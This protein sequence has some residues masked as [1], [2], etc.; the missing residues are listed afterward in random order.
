MQKKLIALAVAGLVSGGAFAQSNVS[1]YGVVDV[2]I[3]HG[4]SGYGSQTRI[5]SGQSAGNRLGFRGEEALGNGLTAYFNLEQGFLLDD[6]QTSSNGS[7]TQGSGATTNGFASPTSARTNSGANVAQTNA[8]QYTFN[9]LAIAGLK[10]SWGSVQIGRQ[11]SPTFAVRAAVD[12]S[13]LGTAASMATTNPGTVDR[14]DNAILYMSPNMGGFTVGLGYTSGSENNSN[15]TV[16]GIGC[17]NAGTAAA[18]D[19]CN[20]DS[21][22]GWGALASYA[23]GPVYVGL[24]HHR[25]NGNGWTAAAGLLGQ[26]DNQTVRQWQLGGTYAFSAAKLHLLWGSNKAS[27]GGL[28]HPTNGD[29]GAD[30]V[31]WAMGVTM[32]MG[33]HKFIVNY[34]QQNGKL[35]S[36]LDFKFFGVHYEYALS[37]R[38]NFYAAYAKVS[39]DDRAGNAGAGTPAGSALGTGLIVNNA[40]GNAGNYDPNALQFGMR[41]SF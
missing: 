2:G 35:T 33:A 36:D 28:T 13:G 10:G 3:E 26:T 15:T 19:M 5:Q 30:A 24:A 20:K 9:R 27:G 7:L 29:R 31:G 22:K 1:I 25:V 4:N 6:G 34:G 12:S 8:G 18:T 14:L 39:N 37:K 11:Y 17:T 41:H 40:A 32:P 21:G 38:T 16:T 23:N